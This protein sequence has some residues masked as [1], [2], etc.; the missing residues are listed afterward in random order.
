MSG[1]QHVTTGEQV[2]PQPRRF[3][4]GGVLPVGDRIGL[5]P[6]PAHDPRIV[7]ERHLEDGLEVFSLER[8]I[9]YDDRHLGE[10]LVPATTDFRTDLTST[11]ALFTWLVPKTGAHL[12]AALV[13]DAL[14]A[15]GGEP[16]Y[17][18]TE[19]HTIDRVEADRVF[20][21][22]MADTG[23]GIVRRWIVWTAVTAATIFAPGGLPR[24][25]AWSPA[26]RWAHRIGAGASI[27][28]ILLLGYWS[29]ADLV[30]RS[31][32]LAREVPWMGEGAWWLELLGG[33]SG[34]V[35]LPLVL[36]LLWG[37]FR[38]AG[39]IAGVM[40]AV[41]LHV[42]L[43]L[44]A[45]LLAYQLLERLASR[46]PRLAIALAVAVVLAALVVFGWFSLG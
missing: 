20:R 25:P 24:S 2:R 34:A 26:V 23:T 28:A 33:V 40:L 37:R 27:A 41:L 45:V 3:Y 12:P 35:V 39:A 32:P 38:I 8:R 18:S 16:S 11:P 43:G 36:G 13:H 22:A 44:A 21:D 30:D 46:A 9:A 10:I 1:S 31:W 6:D 19:G 7:L 14:V 17:D 15:G 5:P 4:D 29:T 42:T